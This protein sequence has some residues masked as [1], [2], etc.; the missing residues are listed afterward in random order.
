MIRGLQRL[1]LNGLAFAWVLDRILRWRAGGAPPP[2]IRSLVVIDA[3]IGRVWPVLSDIE[4]QPRWMHDMKSVEMT[5]PG[6]IR[7]GSR[8]SSTVRMLGISVSDPVTV[9]EFQ[10]PT[11]FAISHDGR[12][13]GGGV[14]TLEPGPDGTTT[15]VRWDETLIA[16]VLPHVAAMAMAPVFRSIFQRDLERLRDLVESGEA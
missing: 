16:P 12:F 9:T 13:T 11:R 4:G 5:T 15:I 1:I 8:G 14:L 10:R 7:V 2:A 6:P 3:P